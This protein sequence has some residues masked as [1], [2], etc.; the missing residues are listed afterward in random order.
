MTE[1]V[2]LDE[3]IFQD[4]AGLLQKTLTRIDHFSSIM[5]DTIELERNFSSF[6]KA[7][8]IQSE[9]VDFPIY[10]PK[11]FNYSE[12]KT[13]NALYEQRL[14]AEKA[15]ASVAERKETR[16]KSSVKGTATTTVTRSKST[17]NSKAD[18]NSYL[19]LIFEKMPAKYKEPAHKKAI[20][21][22][23]KAL[24]ATKEGIYFTDMIS[25]LHMAKTKCTEYMNILVKNG[26][27]VKLSR[28]VLSFISLSN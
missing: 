21:L 26:D 3:N 15:A 19:K 28:K 6:L 11:Q 24:R 1:V 9:C 7:I 10:P 13:Q 14:A 25:T 8:T 17:R 20:T 12:W 23:L 2:R 22:I 4:I 16:S 5:N 18:D 27:V